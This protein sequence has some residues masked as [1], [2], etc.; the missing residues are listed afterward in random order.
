MSVC[1]KEPAVS[2]GSLFCEKRLDKLRK[3]RLIQTAA[4]VPVNTTV[5]SRAGGSSAPRPSKSSQRKY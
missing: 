3:K 2:A 4:G 1:D 5:C